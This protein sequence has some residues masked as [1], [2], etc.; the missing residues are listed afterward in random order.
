M[1]YYGNEKGKCQFGGWVNELI[2]NLKQN[3]NNITFGYAYVNNILSYPKKQINDIQVYT[4]KEK[5][6]NYIEKL[7]YNWF[8]YKKI[9]EPSYINQIIDIIEDFKP[10]IIHIFGVETN[11]TS[12][13]KYTKVPCLVHIQ[14]IINSCYNSY[15]PSGLSLF[16]VLRYNFTFNEIILNSKFRLGYRKMKYQAIKE[17][18]YYKDIK[19]ASGRTIWD[20]NLL[21]IFSPHCS[22]YHIDEILREQFYLSPKWTFK[23]KKEIIITTTISEAM[24]KGLDLVLKTAQIIKSNTFLKFKWYIIGVE[25]KSNYVKFIESAINIKSGN[26]HIVYL[27]KL[28]ANMIIEYLLNS[29]FYIHPSYID[30]SPNSLCEAQY[31]GVPSIACFT[32]GIP[33]LIEHKV[34][35]ILTSIN[36]PFELASY[37][38]QYHDNEEFLSKLSLSEILIAEKRHNKLSIIN[39]TINTY[40]DI[41][42]VASCQ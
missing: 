29:T 42:N 5:R 8:S 23:D 11:L 36:D 17:L 30:N 13:I 31:L 19:Y 10:D 3:S 15:F 28:D 32:G 27:G 40:K 33:T 24:Y 9:K 41:L 37:I 2:V 7:F 4:I 1:P 34:S 35:G 39:N 12:I 6:P 38:I 16:S 26:N 25:N 21:K 20:K 14:G 22:Y 18:A